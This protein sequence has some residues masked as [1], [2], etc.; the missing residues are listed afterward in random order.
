M[1]R[2]PE[3]VVKDAVKKWL[4]AR[5]VWYYMP[6]Q[7]GMGVTGIPDFVCCWQG[8]FLAIETKAPGKR[9]NVSANQEKQIAGIAA[10]GGVAVVVD[11]VHQLEGLEEQ[12][13][14]QEA[15]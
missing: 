7:N 2:T 5:G 8:S 14:H 3:A 13:K 15:A 9:A 10:A 6:L 1:A 11:D 12:W 4:K